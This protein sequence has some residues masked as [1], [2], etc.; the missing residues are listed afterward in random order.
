MRRATDADPVRALRQA[1]T[2]SAEAAV[3][4]AATIVVALSG[5]R[6]SMVLL[7]ALNAAASSGGHAIAAVHVHHGL[8]P[9]ADKWANFCAEHCAA[10]GVPLEVRKV[11]VA[12]APQ[13]SLEATARSV[14]YAALSDAAS[15][16][17]AAHVALAHHRDDQ[18]ETL[19]LQLLRG[20]GPRGLAGMPTTAVTSD[21]I[22][23]LR[24]LLTTS[25]TS[26]DAYIDAV[27]L[28][29]VD[30]ESNTSAAHRRN[31]VRLQVMPVLASVFPHPEL[32]L[33][34]AAGLQA[35]A[36]RLA[37]DLAALDAG[38]GASAFAPALDRARLAALPEYRAANVLRWHLRQLGLPAPSSARLASML[39]QLRQARADGKVHIVHA[40]RAIGV[41]RG[42]VIVHALP[43][44]PFDVLWR[45][46]SALTLPHGRLLFTR[47][48]GQGLDESL[49]AHGPVRIR[50]RVG[51]ER[52]SIGAGRP[53]R[54]VKSLLQE[55][56]VPAWQRDSL[57]LAF[58][59]DDLLWV[60]GLG[61]AAGVAA[62]APA[63]GVVMT[64]H[65][66][67]STINRADD[68]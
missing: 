55:A 26:I 23:W 50:S 35:N 37:D 27:Q 7:D 51:G 11:H 8:S 15:T 5:G 68:P 17:G 12:R 20:A 30:D 60:A 25:R 3:P 53:R 6:D 36:A 46:E 64:W 14:R 48:A 13:Q 65:P 24:P 28:R 49:L 1:V 21:G 54:A 33:A 4:A 66:N 58:C 52:L 32:T 40:G 43:T 9:N 57:P 22:T 38:D 16:L 42:R 45:G 67:E 18:A 41:H 34:R 10:L 59:G 31:A 63:I 19:L 56:G 29:Y 61:F 62:I 47:R 2:Q 39:A 44:A